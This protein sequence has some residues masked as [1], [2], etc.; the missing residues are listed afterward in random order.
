M[1][2]LQEAKWD[3]GEDDAPGILSSRAEGRGQR[4]EGRRKPSLLLALP[5]AAD[6]WKKE[7]T[8]KKGQGR[9]ERL[10]W[11]LCRACRDSHFRSCF[12]FFSAALMQAINKMIF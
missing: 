3:L 1:P 9:Q 10:Y 8:E 12:G 2:P 5:V 7:K 6:V 4:E 11:P